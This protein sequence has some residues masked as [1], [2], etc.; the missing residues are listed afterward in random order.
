MLVSKYPCDASLPLGLILAY[1]LKSPENFGQHNLAYGCPNAHT[2]AR[3]PTRTY[4]KDF[5]SGFFREK[6]SKVARSHFLP[7]NVNFFSRRPAVRRRRAA[8][9]KFLAFSLAF[10]LFSTKLSADFSGGTAGSNC[11]QCTHTHTHVHTRAARCSAV[12][13]AVAAGVNVRR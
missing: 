2:E 1:F 12:A 9:E 4:I 10:A 6:I 11:P 7:R 13:A 3:Y 8:P 5:P